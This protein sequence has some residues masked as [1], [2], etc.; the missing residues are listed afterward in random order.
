MPV[1]LFGGE[2]CGPCAQFLSEEN[3]FDELLKRFRQIER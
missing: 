2:Y 1:K 3:D